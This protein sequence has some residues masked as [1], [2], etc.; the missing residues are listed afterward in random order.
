MNDI[1]PWC[2]IFP[3]CNLNYNL[4]S[5]QGTDRRPEGII[6][7]FKKEG[8]LK[9]DSLV[10]SQIGSLRCPLSGVSKEAMSLP[11]PT[12]YESIKIAQ[13]QE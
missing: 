7:D 4:G 12:F 6:V 5:Y 10:K 9:I 2:P 1:K 11:D 3:D 8:V 13:H